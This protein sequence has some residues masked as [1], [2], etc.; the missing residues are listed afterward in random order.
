MRGFGSWW[1]LSRG[2]CPKSPNPLDHEVEAAKR[3]SSADGGS[4]ILSP[5]RALVGAVVAGRTAKLA[6]QLRDDG[7][8]IALCAGVSRHSGKTPK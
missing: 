7:S 8:A 5:L 4:R 6:D 3:F 1:K 2:G